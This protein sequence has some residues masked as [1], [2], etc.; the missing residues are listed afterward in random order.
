VYGRTKILLVP[1]LW[2]EAYGRVA[3]EAQL[4]GIPVITS[5]RG[6]LPEAVGTGGITLDPEGPLEAW[7]V[8]TRKLWEEESYYAEMSRS[9]TTYATREEMRYEYQY[10]KMEQVMIHAA[11]NKA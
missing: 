10:A 2:E 3:T 7:V 4:S 5:N 9:A 11:K 1:S 6:G 8:A